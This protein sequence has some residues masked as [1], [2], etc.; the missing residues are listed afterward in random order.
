MQPRATLKIGLHNN[1]NVWLFRL[2][3]N[4]LQNAQL[5]FRINS[6]QV[7]SCACQPRS[8]FAFGVEDEN[9]LASVPAF[10]DAGVGWAAQ[11]TST[12]N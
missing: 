11:S 7:F 1:T 3:H 10:K 8:P 2:T 4:S 12:A 6:P 5:A 9:M